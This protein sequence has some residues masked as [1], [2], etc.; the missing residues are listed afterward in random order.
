MWKNIKMDNLSGIDKC[1]G[2]F[3]IWLVGILPCAK[4]KVK[5]FEGVDGKFTGYTGVKL[6]RIFDGDFESAVG[7]GNTIET[8]LEDTIRYFLE[9]VSEDYPNGLNQEH[10]E[11]CDFSDF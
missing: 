8:A 6:K 10:I 1:V 3:D 5:I 4:M 2:E 7:Y 9:M 11:Y